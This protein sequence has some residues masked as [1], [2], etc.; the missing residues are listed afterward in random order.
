[1]SKIL[2]FLCGLFFICN[3]ATQAT[4]IDLPKDT[5]KY[6]R[7]EKGINNVIIKKVETPTIVKRGQNLVIEISHEPNE[8]VIVR[9]HSSL[10]RLIREFKEVEKKIVVQTHKFLP[11]LY[12]IIIKK[13]NQREVRK[14]LVTD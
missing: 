7:I 4:N 12:L 8:K 9:L 13:N 6:N 10:G 11:G 5:I 14:V 2:L 3:Y 1:M